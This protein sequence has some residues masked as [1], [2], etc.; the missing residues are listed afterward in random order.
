M[1]GWSAAGGNYPGWVGGGCLTES[2]LVK[3]SNLI[4][5]SEVLNKALENNLKVETTYLQY[6]QDKITK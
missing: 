4:C 6:E 3:K 2:F 1:N 5:S